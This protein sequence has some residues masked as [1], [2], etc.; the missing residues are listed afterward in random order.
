[1]RRSVVFFMAILFAAGTLAWANGDGEQGVA[2]SKELTGKVEIALPGG[3]YVDVMKTRVVPYFRK[4]YP[5][6]E[7]LVSPEGGT[8]QLQARIA[9]GNPPNVYA[10]VFGYQPV[11]FAKAQSIIALEDMPGAAALLAA[12]DPQFVDK[13]LGH[14]YYIPWNA[15]TTMMIYNKD[16]FKEAGLDPN[17]PPATFDEFLRA[18]KTISALPKRA[19]GTPVYGT[20]FWNEALDWGGWYWSMLAP[21]Y[22]TINGGKYPLFN[23]LGTDIVF[24]KPEARFVEF[25]RFI[26]DAQQYAPPVMDKGFFN[27]NIGMWLQFGFGWKT[28]LK[29][30]KDAPMEVGADVGVAPLPAPKTGDTSWSTLDGRAL[31]I[32]RTSAAQQKLDWEF[33]KYLMGRDINLAANIA[34]GQLPTLKALADDPFYSL[35]QNKPFVAQLKTTILNE[36]VGELDAVAVAIEKA[37][38]EAAVKRTK[39]PEEAAAAAVAAARDVLKKAGK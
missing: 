11:T 32:F 36:P 9:A 39:T 16:L 26:R 22:Y 17:K 14:V 21:I 34:L 28:N 6:I 5:N 8:D 29:Q 12:I 13:S 3:D 2:G 7:V 33:V 30:A 23:A 4:A 20:V 37:I 27:R 10:G 25:L 38:A 1:M 24:D 18:A 19:D 15:T 35:P 31:M